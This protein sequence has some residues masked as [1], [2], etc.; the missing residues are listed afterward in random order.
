MRACRSREVTSIH[1]HQVGAVLDQHQLY[2]GDV[3]CNAV[4]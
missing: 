1:G 4:G 3:S 2:T